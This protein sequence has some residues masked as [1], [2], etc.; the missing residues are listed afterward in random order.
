MMPTLR[1]RLLAAALAVGTMAPAAAAMAQAAPRAAVGIDVGMATPP[2]AARL[3]RL[4]PPRAGY[5]WA[6]GYWAWSPRL[7]RHVWVDGR[8]LRARPGY[9]Y[10]PA[11]W[12]RGLHGRWHFS[13]GHW[14]R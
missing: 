2:P 7:H 3:E 13:A 10:T 8:W 9:R 6:P 5:V 14:T 11:R 12:R 4:P 1:M